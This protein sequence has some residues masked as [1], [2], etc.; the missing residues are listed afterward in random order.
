MYGISLQVKISDDGIGL[1]TERH[2]G[3]GLRSM[4]ERAEELGGQLAIE[5]TPNQGT[6]VIAQLP[7]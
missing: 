5:T 6:C 7:I 3:I 1:S 2:I 4:R